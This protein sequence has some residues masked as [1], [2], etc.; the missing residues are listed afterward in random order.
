MDIS[1]SR[2]YDI[3]T[4]TI[5]S[6]NNFQDIKN[7]IFCDFDTVFSFLI[8]Y[9]RKNKVNECKAI[10]FQKNQFC[11]EYLCAHCSNMVAIN[12]GK[13]AVIEFFA[14]NFNYNYNY[15]DPRIVERNKMTIKFPIKTICDSCYNEH[16]IIRNKQQR[17]EFLVFISS[18]A[19][20]CIV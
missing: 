12:T 17:V 19:I 4:L 16:I 20:S 14:L 11:M 8:K 7:I 18:N 1:T 5:L 3:D 10:S 6:A 2:K 15:R 13:T 9:F